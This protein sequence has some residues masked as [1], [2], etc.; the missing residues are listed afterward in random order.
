M[1]RKCVRL[2]VGIHRT[3]TFRLTVKFMCTEGVVAWHET[4]RCDLRNEY[5]IRARGYNNNRKARYV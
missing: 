3:Q 4:A 5:N 1:C 2:G